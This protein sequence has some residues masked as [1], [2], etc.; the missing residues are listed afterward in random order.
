MQIHA[1]SRPAIVGAD[2]PPPSGDEALER[3]IARTVWTEIHWLMPKNRTVIITVNGDDI[4][5]AF[6]PPR[7]GRR[8]I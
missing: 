1:N 3:A 5:V 2:G 6:G 8:T 7:I 4:R